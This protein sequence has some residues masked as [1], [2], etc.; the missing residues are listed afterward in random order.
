MNAGNELLA[1]SLLLG[2]LAEQFRGRNRLLLHS[3]S[4][5]AYTQAVA[6]YRGVGVRL[7]TTERERA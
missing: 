7:I 2:M 1:C 3:L 5:L 6:A 4:F